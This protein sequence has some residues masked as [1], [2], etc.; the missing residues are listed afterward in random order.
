[1]Y[2]QSWRRL[3]RNVELHWLVTLVLRVISFLKCQLDWFWITL[4]LD[5]WRVHRCKCP[6]HR[7]S[8]IQTYYLLKYGF[9]IK[10]C[11]RIYVVFHLLS[12]M[13]TDHFHVKERVVVVNRPQVTQTIGYFSA[14]LT[15]IAAL[16]EAYEGQW[17]HLA[18][19]TAWWLLYSTCCSASGSAGM[20]EVRTLRTI[21]QMELHSQHCCKQLEQCDTGKLVWVGF[22]EKYSLSCLF[23]RFCLLFFCSVFYQWDHWSLSY[24]RSHLT[25]AIVSSERCIS[26]KSIEHHVKRH[27]KEWFRYRVETNTFAISQISPNYHTVNMMTFDHLLCC[28]HVTRFKL[29]L[30]ITTDIN[31]GQN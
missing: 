14:G 19:I 22:I 24:S 4:L 16:S 23:I 7:W 17:P 28:C 11:W 25:A 6:S 29:L 10:L 12:D 31:D 26:Q 15:V 20:S 9:R 18:S 8:F 1:M 21:Q 3:S 30:H 2:S 5:T 27:N 13:N